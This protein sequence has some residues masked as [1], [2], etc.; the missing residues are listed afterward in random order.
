M[1]Q[2]LIGWTETACRLRFPLRQLLSQ[3]F[4]LAV[5]ASENLLAVGMTDWDRPHAGADATER[6]LVEVDGHGVDRRASSGCGHCS[7]DNGVMPLVAAANALQGGNAFT[8]PSPS[9]S[10]LQQL[11]PH[12]PA[13]LPQSSGCYPALKEL[14]VNN[15]SLVV[16]LKRSTAAGCN[17]YT[18]KRSNRIAQPSA[19]PFLK[20]LGSSDASRL[21]GSLKAPGVTIAADRQSGVS[22]LEKAEVHQIGQGSCGLL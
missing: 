10:Q 21:N 9:L 17:E 20:M 16:A 8:A 12:I 19:D 6:R 4:N 22:E 15:G 1:A 11:F 3:R 18:F 14:V 13:C 2:H 5:Q 7:K